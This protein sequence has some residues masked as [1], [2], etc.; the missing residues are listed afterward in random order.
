MP[1]SVT[2][3]HGTAVPFELGDGS[4][5]VTA[6]GLILPAHDNTTVIRPPGGTYDKQFQ[7]KFRDFIAV[8]IKI[9]LVW[10]FNVHVPKILGKPSA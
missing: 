10:W 2:V 8:S 9:N 1:L 4:S 3:A 7:I 6:A 5:V